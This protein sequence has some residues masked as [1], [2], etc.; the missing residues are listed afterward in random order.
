MLKSNSVRC[1]TLIFFLFS[2]LPYS[3]FN[4]QFTAAGEIKEELEN[5]PDQHQQG[6]F[7]TFIRYF[8]DKYFESPFI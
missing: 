5:F 1:H 8:D 7:K 2:G 6:G 3:I 4:L